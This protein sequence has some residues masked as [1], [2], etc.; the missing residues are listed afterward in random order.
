MVSFDSQVQGL[1]DLLRSARSTVALAVTNAFV[2]VPTAVA[3]A[4]YFY[5]N[6]NPCTAAAAVAGAAAVPL[7]TTT[8]PVMG[9]NVLDV[10]TLVVY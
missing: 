7:M 8:D 6:S 4:S 2:V 5:G 9:P 10:R 3:C 1:A